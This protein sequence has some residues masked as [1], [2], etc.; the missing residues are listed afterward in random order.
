M[1]DKAVN[2]WSLYL[3]LFLIGRRLKKLIDRVVSEDHFLIV[4]CPDKYKTQTIC[5]ETVYDCLAAL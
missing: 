2:R 1:Y 5:D 4:H 3:I